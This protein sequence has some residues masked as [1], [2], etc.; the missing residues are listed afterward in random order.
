MLR[1]RPWPYSRSANLGSPDDA[2]LAQTL[3]DDL[4]DL[5]SVVPELRVRPRG[6]TA[7]FDT[8]HQDVREAGRALDVD[9]VV[10]GSVRR[11]DDVLRVSV[12]LVTVEDGFQLWA[13]RFD[14]A[15]ADVLSVGDDA[16]SAIARALATER[17][18]EARPAP[19]DPIAQDLY[20]RG[21]FLIQGGWLR[22]VSRRRR[23]AA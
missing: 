16:A 6:Q 5:L 11:V 8:R 3:T 2:Y 20:L 18:A 14:R 9:V 19:V 4:I 23:L 22:S 21:R 7:R 10:D 13:R 15:P 12:R 1:E 17:T